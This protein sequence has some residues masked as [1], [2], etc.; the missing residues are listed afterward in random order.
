MAS[1][2]SLGVHKPSALSFLVSEGILPDDPS[3]DTYKWQ[4][5]VQHSKGKSVSEEELITTDQCVVWSRG[6]DVER[7]FRFNVEK[8]AIAHAVFSNIALQLPPKDQPSCMY[9]TVD[10]G[11]T[12]G[13][14]IEDLRVNR[15]R[16]PNSLAT[17]GAGNADHIESEPK[18][19][20]EVGAH[21]EPPVCRALVVF[22]KTQAHIFLI[23]GTSHVVHLPFEVDSVFPCFQG[24]ILQRKLTEQ[25]VPQPTPV[26]PPAPPN[27]FSYSQSSDTN[28][29]ASYPTHSGPN[30][31]SYSSD[32]ES[33]FTPLLKKLQAGS[34][35]SASLVLP[36]LF[37]LVDPLTEIGTVVAS[38]GPGTSNGHDS[39]RFHSTPY[40]N[41]DPGETL[42]YVSPE[43][44]T[45]QRQKFPGE[46]VPLILAVT[47]NYAH[48]TI[49]VWSVTYADQRA[50]SKSET[51]PRKSR[52][53]NVPRRRS[54]FAS[55]LST[56]A[57]TPLP[58]SHRHASRDPTSEGEWPQ[59]S[60]AL[61]DPAFENPAISAKSS[62]RVSSLLARADLS[63]TH[64]KSTFTDLAAGHHGARS[65]RRGASSGLRS[66]QIA[67][68]PQAAAHPT[69]PRPLNDIRSSIDSVSLHEQ[70]LDENLDEYHD[71]YDLKSMNDSCPHDTAQGLRKEI[72]FQRVYTASYRCTGPN[73]S[74]GYDRNHAAH[75]FT[76]KAPDTGGDLDSSG[77][78]II[79][80]VMNR[81][82][83]ELLILQIKAALS[84]TARRSRMPSLFKSQ[85]YDIR[86]TGTRRSG[87]TDACRVGHGGTNRILVL[88]GKGTGLTLQAPWTTLLK[89]EL[90]T[91]LYDTYYMTEQEFADEIAE[92]TSPYQDT[93]QTF[94][95]QTSEDELKGKKIPCPTRF[96]SLNH[97]TCEGRVDIVDTAGIRHRIQIALQPSDPLASRM[98]KFCESVLPSSESDGEAILRGW[99]DAM[100]WL[101]TRS[102]KEPD[103]EWTAMVLLLFSMGTMFMDDA[104]TETTPRQK[105][106]PVGSL[107]GGIGANVNL[108]SWGSIMRHQNSSSAGI[109]QWMR[110][111]AW[112]WTGKHVTLPLPPSQRVRSPNTPLRSTA[113]PLP[114][115]SPHIL[116]C[117]SLARDFL[118]SPLGEAAAGRRGYLP[119]ASSR[120]P[121]LRRTALASILV[122]LHLLREELKLNILAE[123]FLHQLTP[124]LAQIGSW[125]G[126]QNWSH[127]ESSYYAMESADMAACLFDDSVI[128]A[129]KV[130]PEPFL[131]PSIFR[132]IEAAHACSNVPPFT[133]LL[134]IVGAPAASVEN[135]RSSM[136]SIL[137]Q[138]TPRTTLITSLLA[139][140]A[141]RTM[142]ERVSKMSS[143]GLDLKMLE[144]LPESVASPFRAAM[145][146]CRAQPSTAWKSKELRMLGR[147]DMNML[148][149]DPTTARVPGSRL[150]V[151]P[152]DTTKDVH[153]ICNSALNVEVVGPYDAH[154]ERDRQYITR[155][156]Y[157]EDQRFIEA[158]KLIHPLHYPVARCEPEPQWTEQ[159]FLEAQQELAKIVALRTLSVS[160][161]RGLLFYSGRQPLA[162]EKFP[163]H[164]FTL[165]CIMKPSD[166]TITADRAT[167][168]EEKV[169][170]AFFHA[171]VEA[172]LSI[173]KDARGVNASWILFNKPRELTNRHAGFLFAL[174]LNG[175]LKSIAKWVSF[176]YLTPKHNMTSIGLLLGLSAS[177]LG[178]MDTLVT[179]LLS[180]HVT[181]MLPPGAAELN[182]SPLTQ[183]CG[184]MGIG[185]LYCNTQ[186]RRMSE[187]MLSEIE[188]MDQEESSNPLDTLRDEGYRLAAGC[189]LGYINVGRGKDLKGLRDMHIT[190]R[191]LRLAIATKRVDIVH[192]A[193]KATAGATIALA[194]IFMKTNDRPLACKID[195]P[196]TIHQFDYVRPDQFLL[197]TVAKHIIMWDSIVAEHGWIA[198]HMPP[199]YQKKTIAS[200]RSLTSE[201]L[202]YFNILAGLCLSIGLRYAGSGSLKV[203]DVLCT[204][205]DHFIRICRLPAISCDGKLARI[206]VR[207]C[208]DVL[209]LSASCV[210]AGTGDL[211]ILRRLRSLHGR[212]DAETP[213]GSHL[214]AHFSI[215][216]LFLGGG[217][218]TF[219][220]SNLATAS[221][222]CAFYPLFPASVLDN[223]SH[224]Q[225]FRHFWVLATEHRCL[226]PREIDTSRPFSLAI[227]VSHKDGTTS[228]HKAPCLL[229]DISTISAIHTNDTQ[230]WPITLSLE[231]NPDHL[232]AFHRRHSIYLRRRYAYDA[233]Q[234]SVFS[235]T[236]R[237]L[238]D[239]Q[240][241]HQIRSQPFDWIFSL[242]SFRGFDKAERALI[243]PTDTAGG[244]SGGVSTGTRGTPVDDRLVIETGCLGDGRSERLWNLRI[245]LKWVEGCESRG[246][247]IGWLSREVVER[248]RAR[249]ALWPRKGRVS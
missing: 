162:T 236:M 157:N 119:T 83:G 109:P 202:P 205:L 176:K 13:S 195:V 138:L 200:V 80:C 52:G 97:A 67:N 172:G 248:L 207:N 34:A 68:D 50:T 125:L 153:S 243:L 240:T 198:T 16:R 159:E 163:I 1:V 62:R 116:H 73:H 17:S 147:D 237:A 161:G 244:T 189:A 228:Q 41:L 169:S 170:W 164:G 177:Y 63:T 146:A 130:P 235:T 190:E 79:L 60:E 113:I 158:A 137:L 122:A 249:L 47:E 104:S 110:H 61:L 203:R 40:A 182:L 51:R 187:I 19:P 174:G 86:V 123:R 234:I 102:D 45:A 42:L 136:P 15:V 66:S 74:S 8:E 87:V 71:I 81:L 55:R 217:T 209:A 24:L 53:G 212:A 98:V 246:E 134:D 231:S 120:D 194:M 191:L 206:T 35:K 103:L 238:K 94:P 124:V 33:P 2:E 82:D 204:Y 114:S 192:V 10:S 88:D 166:T 27:T 179:R 181:R 127:K 22:L 227:L 12:K 180:V 151:P 199:V 167:F 218:H 20:A 128:T 185:L 29:A 152:T 160:L 58:R 72:L 90:P 221:L 7:I 30:D 65:N 224:L 115:E 222:L 6:G 9:R 141:Q 148:E 156:V 99:W 142:E 112:Q 31:L 49:S 196:D 91:T 32:S 215:G 201:D 101:Q 64:D 14:E 25:A 173:S 107:R 126:W 11:K 106:R 242:P 155:L 247:Q 154:A 59:E 54:S 100:R 44:E 111:G 69:N 233:A 26:L 121:D 150:G 214:A 239:T 245:L 230:Y 210:V 208:Q 38:E 85:V 28:Q 108:D 37:S 229:P 132:Y 223:K 232:S 131:P 143:L 78:T 118:K 117:I 216:I 48:Q 149:S 175:H 84:R 96:A 211:V 193:D 21:E 213:Y 188:N 184:I 95:C 43:D 171:G 57:T 93:E 4:T 168:T 220:T 165:S 241:A 129:L 77:S 140:H 18:E 178:T 56:G 219:G 46:H 39:R 226:V 70:Q 145:A 133:T 36:R 75:V 135:P 139:S 183:T 144:T 197:R 92:Q 186:H 105:E 23:S 225:A 89:V 5:F 3:E 76:L